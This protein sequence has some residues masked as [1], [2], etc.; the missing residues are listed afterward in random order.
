MAND[1]QRPNDVITPDTTVSGTATGTWDA[2]DLGNGLA[3]IAALG[4]TASS[5]SFGIADSDDV[6][7]SGTVTF[8]Y[9]ADDLAIYVSYNGGTSYIFDQS[10][11]TVSELTD[12]EVE[13]DSSQLGDPADLRIGLIS[14]GPTNIVNLYFNL[15]LI[16]SNIYQFKTVN[17]LAREII[18]EMGGRVTSSK[19]ISIVERWIDD[20]YRKIISFHDWSWAREQETV[21]LVEGTDAYTITIPSLQISGFRRENGDKIHYRSREQLTN[22]GWNFEQTGSPLFFYSES[23]NGGAMVVRFTP[24]PEEAETLTAYGVPRPIQLAS[25]DYIPLPNE[26]MPVLKDGVRGYYSGNDGHP[27]DAARYQAFFEQYL[28]LLKSRYAKEPADMSRFEVT[29]IPNGGI[30]TEGRWGD[31]FPN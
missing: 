10:L 11:S 3:S 8:Q 18:E 28:S 12:V 4:F 1:Q 25:G 27:E 24:V 30:V 21:T 31:N 29:D 2:V 13:L 5:L 26:F 23:H 14:F 17:S 15:N 7:L 22:V 19:M 6:L 16:P 9:L 20:V